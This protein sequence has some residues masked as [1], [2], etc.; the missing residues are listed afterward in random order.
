MGWLVCLQAARH[1]AISI[2]ELF[3][4]SRPSPSK[5][6]TPDDSRMHAWKK[7]NTGPSE[8]ESGTQEKLALCRAAMDRASG[9]WDINP[10]YKDRVIDAKN[11]GL[12]DDKCLNILAELY[13]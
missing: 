7:Y 11:A 6:I 1:L 2:S 3:L 5:D 9:R 12:T 13:P 10:A 8:L 4:T